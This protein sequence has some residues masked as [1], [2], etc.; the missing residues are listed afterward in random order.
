MDQRGAQLTPLGELDDLRSLVARPGDVLTVCL[1][2]RPANEE[3]AAEVRLEWRALREEAERA[4]APS[5]ALAVVDR[6]VAG[7]HRDHAGLHVVVPSDGRPHVEG[8]E[9]PPAR[10]SVSWGPVPALVPLLADRQRRQPHVVVLVDRQGADIVAVTGRTGADS[11]EGRA[12]EGDGGD[13]RTKTTVDGATF[14]LRKVAPGGWSQRRFQQHAEETWQRNMTEVAG[15]VTAQAQRVDARFVALGGDERAVGLLVDHLPAAVAELV[16][17]LSVTRATDGSAARLD[18]EVDRVLDDWLHGEM[19]KTA[20]TY[21]EELGQGDRAVAGPEQTLDALRAAR[22]AQL[23]VAG[24]AT[25]ANGATGGAA[26]GPAIADAAEPD[27]TDGRAWIGATPEDVALS[28]EALLEGSEARSTPLLDAA[29]AA[30]L[31]TGADIRVL[32]PEPAPS[33][34]AA[35][36]ADLPDLPDLP[37][38]L[39]ALLR[40]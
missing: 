19:T 33:A 6:A 28:R 12:M 36:V 16:R 38:G 3:L 35:P 40:W 24:G 21:R 22:V 20:D 15:E 37:G 27:G 4:G 11:P 10:G 9:R 8:L 23:L 17:P 1:P 18:D 25:G 26:G 32:P 13:G 14:P 2:L 29:I 31:A 5:E 39:G 7:A 30:A 34:G